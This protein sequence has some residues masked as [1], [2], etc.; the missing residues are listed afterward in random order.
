MK[1]DSIFYRLFKER[2]E[3]FFELIER[4]VQEAQDYSFASYEVKQTAFR[5]DGFFQPLQEDT[6]KPLYFTEVQFR[7]DANV[8]AGLFAE[9]F[10]YLNQNNPG[11]DWRGIIIFATRGFEPKNLLPY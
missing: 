8:Y 7:Y 1:T 9:I 11:Q 3:V 6:T 5:I 10:I 2:G 4:P